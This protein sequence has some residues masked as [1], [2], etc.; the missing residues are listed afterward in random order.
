MKI[1][2]NLNPRFDFV[3]K[4]ICAVSKISTKCNCDSQVFPMNSVKCMRHNSRKITFQEV[5]WRKNPL[6]V[7]FLLFFF[8]SFI[9]HSYG[10]R[11]I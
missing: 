8:L 3:I 2:M 11:R 6:F 5:L 9:V 7:F 10:S 1:E 4:V